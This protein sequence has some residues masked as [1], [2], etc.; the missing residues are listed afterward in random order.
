[1]KI[2]GSAVL[3]LAGVAVV[4]LVGYLVYKKGG[5]LVSSIDP[6]NPD[7][8]VNS[9]A[10]SAYAAV[11]GREGT[12]IGSDLYDAVQGAR[13]WFGL[14][15]DRTALQAP[16]SG[17]TGGTAPGA[18]GGS[19]GEYVTRTGSTTSTENGSGVYVP[20]NLNDYLGLG[21]P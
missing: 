17:A 1:M 21:K 7:N 8:V 11:T 3:A 12:S 10:Q 2:T 15:Y 13:R 20:F 18:P 6:T 14:D 5:A 19:R 4:G 16:Y 9:A